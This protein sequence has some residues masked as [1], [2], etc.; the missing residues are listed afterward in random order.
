[1]RIADA[2]LDRYPQNLGALD[3]AVRVTPLVAIPALAAGGH[4]Y[5]AGLVAAT[6][7]GVLLVKTALTGR[8]I[9]YRGLGLS[10]CRDHAQS[11]RADGSGS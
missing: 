1:M 11:T 4:L 7:V 5:G 9:L 10:T 3:R 8:C 2:L 6:S